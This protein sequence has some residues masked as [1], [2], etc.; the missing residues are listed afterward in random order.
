MRVNRRASIS[1]LLV[2]G[3]R[4]GEEL[5]AAAPQAGDTWAL[6]LKRLLPEQEPQSWAGGT[7]SVVDEFGLVVFV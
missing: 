3:W 2:G 1:R 5:A 7:E 6:S 4:L